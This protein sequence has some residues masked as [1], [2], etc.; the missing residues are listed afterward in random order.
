M[1]LRSALTTLRHN[2][3]LGVALFVPLLSILVACTLLTFSIGAQRDSVKAAAAIRNDLLLP[4]LSKTSW[5]QSEREAERPD[6]LDADELTQPG[7]AP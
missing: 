1:S 3:A 6:E 4:P 7:H 2:P 5:R